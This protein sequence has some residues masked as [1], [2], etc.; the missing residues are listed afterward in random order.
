MAISRHRQLTANFSL[1][2][3]P[4]IELIRPDDFTAATAD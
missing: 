2:S 4:L 3:K 1:I